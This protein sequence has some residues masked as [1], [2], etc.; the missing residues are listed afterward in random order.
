MVQLN[1]ISLK[2]QRLTISD[3]KYAVYHLNEITSENIELGSVSAADL[4][5]SFT[6]SKKNVLA[7]T[8]HV[9]VRR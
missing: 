9:L 1:Q 4:E 2:M 5:I 8:T 3:D 7:S 6:E